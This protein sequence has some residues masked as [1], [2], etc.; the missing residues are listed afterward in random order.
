M[1]LINLRLDDVL[2][3]GRL[4]IYT[5]ALDTTTVEIDTGSRS[6]SV[7]LTD[8]EVAQIHEATSHL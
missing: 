4:H 6:L 5:N 3:A 2:P 7:T 8:A 1:M